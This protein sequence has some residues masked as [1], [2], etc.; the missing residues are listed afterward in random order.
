MR[1]R[2]QREKG[3]EKGRERGTTANVEKQKVRPGGGHLS[4][5]KLVV[6]RSPVVDPMTCAMFV[7]EMAGGRGGGAVDKNKCKQVPPPA[8]AESPKRKKRAPIVRGVV[9]RKRRQEF[10]IG[11][12]P[13][14]PGELFFQPPGWRFVVLAPFFLLFFAVWRDSG[15]RAG[16]GRAARAGLVPRLVAT[17][18]LSEARAGG[19]R[20]SCAARDGVF[21]GHGAPVRRARSGAQETTTGRRRPT[22]SG[23]R[24]CGKGGRARARPSGVILT[25][26]WIDCS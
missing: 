2:E 22:E 10:L 23:R 16:G 1:G 24:C 17:A 19:Q 20:G 12:K 6:V 9:V 3:R 8:Q 15:R 14:G 7:N 18:A 21:R 5:V 11:K 4:G 26:P 13:I 25:H